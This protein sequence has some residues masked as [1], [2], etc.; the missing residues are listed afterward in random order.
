MLWEKQHG[1]MRIVAL[2]EQAAARGLTPGTSIPDAKAQVPDLDAR[3][4]DHAQ[5]MHLFAEFADWHSNASPLVAILKVHAPYGDLCLDITGVTHL[6]GG[7][8]PMLETLVARLQT[9]GFTVNGAIAGTIGAAWALAHFAPGT[10]AT[11]DGL[12]DRLAPLPVAAL[13]LTDTPIDGLR[14][15][16]LK[17]IGQLYGRD[18]K[19]LA[20]RFGSSLVNRLD[21]ALGYVEE[22]LTPRLP[23]AEYFAE[24]RFAEPI[25]LIDDVLM[26]AQDLAV[27]LA[28]RL[29]T[30]GLGAQSYHLFL[31]L[32]DH[33]MIR[34]SVNAARPT[35]DAA[36]IARLFQHRAERL[37]GEYDP[38][39]GI[40]M[41]RLGA[42]SISPLDSTQLGA[43]A[44][45]DGSADLMQ[46]FDRMTSRLGPLAV[47][48]AI[49]IDTHIPEQ[50]VRFEPVVAQAPAASEALDR[51]PL[52][53]RPLRL[54]PHPEPITVVAEV[55][56]GPPMG[57]V[58]RRVRYRFVRG[59]GPERIEAEWWRSG[60]RLT[61]LPVVEEPPKPDEAA[62]PAPPPPPEPKLETF[63]PG[64]MVRDYYVAEDETG[65]RFWLFRQG[66]YDASRAPHWYLHGIFA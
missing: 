64:A 61:L 14:Q 52:P 23:V 38:G 25:G 54:L 18:R 50:A 9:R 43:F 37:A 2:D 22:R 57:M 4:I 7:E 34:L 8:A 53:A 3:E 21:Q 55:P 11:G 39:F 56:D 17:R 49:P 31:Y 42:S 48:H 1:G 26:C 19:A 27:Q 65:R 12:D 51:P 29:E 15:M 46:L 62:A 10:I 63:E 60:Q 30:N 5:I 6:F 32:A 44:D 66:L 59:A 24:R 47:L 20:A 36:H 45:P 13:R 33:R 40:D 28:H 41:I 16:G 35:R 58:W